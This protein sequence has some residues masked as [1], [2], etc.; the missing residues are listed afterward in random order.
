MNV[1]ILESTYKRDFTKLLL[2]A[3]DETLSSLG[4]SSKR[5]I[6]FYLERNFSIK[7]QDIPDR[8]EEFTEAIEKLFGNGAK[9]L[10]IQIMKHLYENLGRDFEYLSEN[11]DLLFTDYANVVRT[12]VDKPARA[13]IDTRRLK[14]L[15]DTLSRN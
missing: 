13:S 4:D 3:V 2:E 11:N 14:S 6:Y 5:A 7:K 8:I 9:I 12:H 1:S 15:N 10:E